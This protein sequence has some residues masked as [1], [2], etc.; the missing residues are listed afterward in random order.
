MYFLRYILVIGGLMTAGVGH[1]ANAPSAGNATVAAK[2]ALQAAAAF[3]LTLTD[4]AG[5]T[6]KLAAKP[7]RII[8]LS[9]A[10]TEMVLA[11]GDGEALVGV[12][13]YCT[14][15]D[16]D[17]P[18]ARIGG[19]LDPD[20][21]QMVALK[22]DLV[23]APNLASSQL[24]ERLT[25]LGLTVVVLSPEGLDNLP[26]DF[27]LTGQAT[28]REEKGEALARQFE[29]LE[30]LARA[31]LQN[32]PPEGRPTAI[33]IYE[34]D[35]LAPGPAAFAGQLLTEA[36]A[37]N[38]VPAGGTAWQELSPEALLK[39]NPETIFLVQDTTMESWPPAQQPALRGLAAVQHGRVVNL[40]ESLFERPGP[41][42]GEAL[43]TLA[44]DLHPDRFPEASSGDALKTSGATSLTP[45][46]P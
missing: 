15:L 2:P 11:L 39:L 34:P 3:P 37:R 10:I 12:T 41:L 42:L 27:R 44:H 43:W 13:R 29:N 21:E 24:L 17:P 5:R 22:P 14:V 33:I 28:G 31:R 45:V 35:L 20:Y 36:G 25:S 30:A 9:P 18:I 7:E 26:K 4:G 46:K 38:V 8:S 23:L 40:P 1:A 6:V 19:L 16:R 32:L